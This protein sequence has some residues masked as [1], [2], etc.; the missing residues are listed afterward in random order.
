MS[1]EG[2][3]AGLSS[4]GMG[5]GPYDDRNM[6]ETPPAPNATAA[7]A[8]AGPAAGGERGAEVP[9]GHEAREPY[10]DGLAPEQPGMEAPPDTPPG[11]A[12]VPPGASHDAH[13]PG[14]ATYGRSDESLSFGEPEFHVPGAWPDPELNPNDFAHSLGVPLPD[15]EHT[16][17]LGDAPFGSLDTFGAPE[18]RG[19]HED[20]ATSGRPVDHIPYQLSGLA[21]FVPLPADS[22]LRRLGARLGR[23]RRRP[24]TPP[25]GD[26]EELWTDEPAP[27]NAPQ[28]WSRFA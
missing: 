25:Y 1:S 23:R 15:L 24:G 10:T 6:H 11:S 22:P 16:D 5:A 7:P 2:Q 14:P 4:G 18:A 28:R 12:P 21:A 20:P 27:D 8:P 9:P 17:F 26:T 13:E 19:A 3:G